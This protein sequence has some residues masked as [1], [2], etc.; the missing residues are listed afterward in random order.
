MSVLEI[1]KKAKSATLTLQSLPEEQ[2][3]MA[4]EA[5]A[6]ALTKNAGRILAENKKDLDEAKT[7]NLGEALV[8]RMVLTE[9]AIADLS[10]MCRDVADQDQVVGTIVEEYTRPNGLVIQKQRIPLGV[11]GMIFESRPNV[12]VDG[13][14]LAIKSGNAIILKGGKEAHHS[15]RVLFE[16]LNEATERILPQGSVS[17]IETREDV[18]ELLK[19]HHYIDLMVPRGGSGLINHVRANATMPVVAHD[20]GLC[21]TFVNEDADVTRVIP[22]VL[23]AKVQRPSACNATETLLL[24]ANYSQNKE[25]VT[26]LI[27]AGVEVR[28]CEKAQKLHA[29]VKAATEKDFDT[30]YLAN[31][32]SVK[33]VN[34]YSEAISHIQKHSSHHTEAV[35]TQDPKVIEEFL[36][37][38]D[39]SAMVVNASTRFNDGGELGLGAELG[40]STSKL[41]AY[42]PMGAKEMTTTRFL[43]KGNGQIR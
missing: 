29:K 35:L 5:I 14:A 23:N 33:I 40:I 24:H 30:E 42:G 31:I 27:D 19:L 38:L 41:H 18:A 28:G 1:A 20:K 25:V 6:V 16:I 4:L 3:L 10:K 8:A 32:I 26:A 36:N 39:A 21:H 9:K 7:N 37:T 43:V 22:I 17:L 12:V 11:I 34:D 2:R 15:N 13:A